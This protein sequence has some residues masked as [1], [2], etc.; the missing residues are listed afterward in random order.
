MVYKLVL[1]TPMLRVTAR[2]LV[3]SSRREV[4]GFLL[5]ALAAGA[6]YAAILFASFRFHVGIPP[7]PSG[8]RG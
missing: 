8:T 6:A 5:F 3:A 2:D 1:A 7:R 4:L